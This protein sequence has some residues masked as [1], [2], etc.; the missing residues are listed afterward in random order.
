[1]P[2][3][4]VSG[5][6]ATITIVLDEIPDIARLDIDQDDFAQNWIPTAFQRLRRAEFDSQIR[7]IVLEELGQGFDVDPV[8]VRFGSLELVIVV[9]TLYRVIKDFNEFSDQIM[10]ARE[11]VR[12]W[13]LGLMNS[14]VPAIS[15]TA[16]SEVSS[17]VLGD[18]GGDDRLDGRLV[19]LRESNAILV[20]LLAVTV[21]AM[22][23]VLITAITKLH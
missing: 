6:V 11:K 5:P 8:R 18:L 10:R 4:A 23:A 12:R 17:L 13:V 2:Q 1:M 19:R 16:T 7:R 21:L 15:V 22:T 3:G 9:S 14:P 20:L